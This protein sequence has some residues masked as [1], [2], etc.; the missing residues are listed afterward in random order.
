MPKLM[1]RKV[2]LTARIRKK[3]AAY[4]GVL[5]GFSLYLVAFGM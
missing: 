5:G 3:R 1:F 2:C 4:S